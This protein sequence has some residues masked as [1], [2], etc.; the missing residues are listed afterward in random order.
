MSDPKL[1]ALLDEGLEILT[2]LDASIRKH[3]NYSPEATCTFIDQAGQCFRE[4]SRSL[5]ALPQEPAPEPV[6]FPTA[7]CQPD[8]PDNSTAFS[9]PGTARSA[10][11]T[12]ALYAAPVP[13]VVG[14][15][16]EAAREVLRELA[17]VKMDLS[18]EDWCRISNTILAA[19]SASSVA[20]GV[21][22]QYDLQRSLDFAGD[23]NFKAGRD[24]WNVI[25]WRGEYRGKIALTV[26]EADALVPR[27]TLSCLSHPAQGWR[28]M[29]SAPR[30]GTSILAAH[31]KAAIV[32]YWQE[33]RTTDGAPGWADG[34][35]DLDGYFHTYPVF[36]WQP[37]P[38]L[39]SAPAGGSGN[40]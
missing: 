8:D 5:A 13:P 18:L 37:L 2:N 29:A 35:T 26:D 9:W 14:E 19:L 39:P 40:E 27:R 33:E 7:F 20:S 4:A 31:D 32:V 23:A 1:N 17:N 12:M 16:A 38:P 25:D 6:K 34:E 30:D 11:H 28:E 24:L 22:A 10:K 36:V 3:G 21:K 15:D